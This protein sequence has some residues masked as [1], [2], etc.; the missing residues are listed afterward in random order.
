ME[1][2]KVLNVDVAIIGAGTAGMYAMSQARRAK[3]KFVLI[4]RGPLGTTCAR[5]GCMPSKVALHAADLWQTQADQKAYGIEGT[6]DLSQDLKATWAK[7][8]AMRDGFAGGTAN[9]C[10][11]AAGES[12][13]M[14]T[15]KFVEP[16]LLEVETEEETLRVQAGSVIIATGSSPLVPAFLDDFKDF[17]ITT[18]DLFELEDLPA[19]VG[20][21]GLGAIGLEMGQALH[22]L[23]IEVYG[24]DMADTI[25]GIKDPEISKAA[26][27]A[28][29]GT[30]PMVLGQPAHLE[31]AEEGV[32]LVSGENSFNVDKVLVAL[33][34]RPNL[35]GL[36]LEGAGFK[37]NDKGIPSY[38]PNTMQI[39]DLPVY[40]AGDINGDRTLMHEAAD[41]GAIAGYNACNEEVVAFERKVPLAVAFTNPDIVSV[42]ASY[43][44]LDPEKVL[45]GSSPTQTNPRTRILSQIPGLL[46]IYADKETG[47][48]L[49]ASMIGP[50][51]EHVGQFLALAISGKMTVEEALAVPYYHPTVEENI[52][53]ALRDLV[54]QRKSSPYPMGLVPLEK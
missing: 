51:G 31:A 38:N 18:N 20:V 4:D 49:G 11:K 50:R 41:E 13:I 35:D 28:F 26:L 21:L 6:E 40:I 39:D 32:D 33:G 42:G 8:S 7:V 17:L 48:I 54:R 1:E 14:G 43:E 15:A 52:Q 12:L 47:L 29:E 45:I 23:G 19:R 34:R 22:R 5:V 3:K 46:R 16:T 2:M 30:F 37:V 36:N 44:S 53:S 10:R 24:A 25:A 9:N 27:K